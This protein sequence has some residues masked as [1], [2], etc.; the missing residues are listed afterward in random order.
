MIKK[1]LI[2]AILILTT[3]CGGILIEAIS[4]LAGDK[5][6][7][8][9]NDDISL[10][11]ITDLR[12]NK[13]K[14]IAVNILSQNSANLYRCRYKRQAQF[15]IEYLTKTKD[16][17]WDLVMIPT[18]EHFPN[19]NSFKYKGRFKINNEDIYLIYNNQK[20]FPELIFSR[21]PNNM[22]SNILESNFTDYSR[23]VNFPIPCTKL[24]DPDTKLVISKIYK[25]DKVIQSNI[26]FGFVKSSDNQ[27]YSI[28]LE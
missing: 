22:V 27:G 19:S 13:G 4:T 24:L 26:E 2:L 1:F 17:D 10:I 9:D 20:I 14:L 11:L 12:E 16:V 18:Q 15:S 3:S 7:P 21:Q 8:M 25:D 23:A 28:W 6:V 5:R